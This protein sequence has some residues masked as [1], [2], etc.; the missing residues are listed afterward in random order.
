[1]KTQPLGGAALR[2]PLALV[3]ALLVAAASGN[4]LL[5]GCGA[6]N[7]SE[8]TAQ[9][10]STT[11]TTPPAMPTDTSGTAGATGAIDA[12]AIFKLRCATCHGPTGHGDGPGA[13]AL[14]PKPRNYH[15][16]AY[17]STRTDEQLYNSIYNGKSQM[18]AWGKLGTLTPDQIRAMVAYVRKLSEQP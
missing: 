15:D 13:V 2:R 10:Q 14:N 3:A 12:G 18:P 5:A 17:M 4:A 8:Q 7:K 16:K 6:G 1:M 9:N 11:T